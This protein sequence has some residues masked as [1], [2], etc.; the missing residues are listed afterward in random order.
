MERYRPHGRTVTTLEA[1]VLK[2]RALEMVLVL[3][4]VENLKGFIISSVKVTK[5]LRKIIDNTQST[6]NNVEQ[7]TFKKAHALLISE[8][9]ITQEE[10]SQLRELI[11][12]RNTIGHEI[13]RITIDIGAYSNLAEYDLTNGHKIAKYN[14]SAVQRVQNLRKKIE[15]K[16]ME[17]SFSFE[18][19]FNTLAFDAAEQAYLKEIKR[20][21]KKVNAGIDKLN[22]TIET[23]NK[24][25]RNIP[26]EV[27]DTVQPGHPKNTKSNG[28]FSQEG[29]KAMFML[30]DAKATP[31]AVAYI[32]RIT[33]R[34]AAK[35]HKKWLSQ[36]K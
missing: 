33:Y 29:A 36:H 26:P 18:L 19:S 13:H 30:Y 5:R 4:Y 8:G 6:T 17:K 22:I 27:M 34:T 3:F 9:I 10:S 35:W 7:I 24:I 1:D 11:D 31:L 21:K 16:M 2:L 14:Y 32:M 28:T 25:I 12:Y 15:R 20:L 23:T